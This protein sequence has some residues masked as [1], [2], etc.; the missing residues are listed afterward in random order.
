VVVDEGAIGGEYEDPE[1]MFGG[2]EH[3]AEGGEL[4]GH[5]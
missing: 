5:A 3:V 1:G 4:G 2:V